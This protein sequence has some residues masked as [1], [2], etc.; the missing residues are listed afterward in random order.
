MV[1]F[2]FFFV[3]LVGL[4][5]VILAL[6]LEEKP[7]RHYLETSSPQQELVVMGAMIAGGAVLLF[8]ELIAMA[9]LFGWWVLVLPIFVPSVA[10][11]MLAVWRMRDHTNRPSLCNPTSDD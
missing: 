10:I 4:L 6:L 5:T 3:L 9:W 11:L 1:S 7:P 2:M 8:L